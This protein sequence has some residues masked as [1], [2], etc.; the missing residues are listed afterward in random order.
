STGTYTL[1]AGNLTNI[2]GDGSGEPPGFGPVNDTSDGVS[3]YV[4]FNGNGTFNQT[5][6]NN[7]LGSPTGFDQSLVIGNAPGSFGTYTLSDATGPSNLA[8]KG[9][10]VVGQSATG[11]VNPVTHVITQYGGTFIQSGGTNTVIGVTNGMVL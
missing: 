8:V 3:E 6:G 9:D 4:G 11:T 1:N 5:G 10:E 7:K 2:N